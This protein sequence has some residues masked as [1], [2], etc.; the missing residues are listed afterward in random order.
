MVDGSSDRPGV[1]PAKVVAA[2]ERLARGHRGRRLAI[3]ATLGLTPLQA[4]LLLTLADGEPPTPAVGLLARELAVTQPTVTD[5]LRALER[6]ALV[7]RRRHPADA[8]RVT[9]TLTPAGEDLVREIAAGD[10]ELIQAVAELPRSSQE[11][12]LEHTLTVISAL[13]STGF[14]SVART[15]LTCRF[16]ESGAGD[17]HYCRLL[18]MPLGPGELR[19]NCP[20]HDAAESA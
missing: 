14:I 4:D 13:V 3:T 9:V 2:L 10:Q 11:A 8:R 16:H 20:E 5:S 7:Q 12:L 1:L 18:N 6:K 17:G 19:I 15:C